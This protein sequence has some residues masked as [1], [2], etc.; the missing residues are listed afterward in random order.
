MTQTATNQYTAVPTG[1]YLPKGKF[2]I[3]VHTTFFGYHTV[4][5]ATYT[6]AW[7]SNP[8]FTA[9]S[10]SYVGGK[11]ITL[12]GAGFLTQNIQNN[13]IQVCGLPAKITDATTSSLTLTVP[14]LVTTVTQG[15]YNLAK[16]S[17][18]VGTLVSDS[19]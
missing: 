12:T 13:E 9:V 2:R 8:T 7:S 16:P 11:S 19:P 3:L 18:I 15:L 10:T 6:K 14:A 4:S 1:G 5:P 17:T